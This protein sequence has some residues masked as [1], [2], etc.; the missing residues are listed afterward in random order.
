MRDLGHVT[1]VSLRELV[2]YDW[3]R[4][5]ECEVSL[6]LRDAAATKQPSSYKD[7]R[8]DAYESWRHIHPRSAPDGGTGFGAAS[9]LLTMEQADAALEIPGHIVPPQ[10]FPSARVHARWTSTL[11]V[12]CQQFREFFDQFIT[13]G[14]REMLPVARDAKDEGDLARYRRMTAQLDDVRFVFGFL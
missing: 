12:M 1:W 6:W 4:T 7:Y 8:D 11:Y 14:T 5:V 9:A 13:D 10:W 3:G 2:E